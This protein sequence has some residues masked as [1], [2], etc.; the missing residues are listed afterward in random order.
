MVRH[1]SP[2]L[3]QGVRFSH[4]LP[5][6]KGSPHWR[7]KIVKEHF[8]DEVSTTGLSGRNFAIS[9]ILILRIQLDLSNNVCVNPVD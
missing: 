1:E 6:N 3:V 9:L 5:H 2:K 7:S 4:P 8:G